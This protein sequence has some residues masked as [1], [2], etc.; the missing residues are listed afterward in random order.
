LVEELAPSRSL[1]RHPL[2]QV[3]LTLQNTAEA[4]LELTNVTAEVLPNVAPVA[5]FDLEVNMVEVFDAHGRPAGLEGLATVAADLFDASTAERVVGWFVRVLEAVTAAPGVR[6]HAVDLLDAGQRE[7]VLVGWNDTVVGGVEATVV[8][9]F[10]RRVVEVPDATAVVA[11]GVEVSYRELD[12]R[13]NRLARYLCGLGV[14]VESVVAV[15]M[16]RGVD[17]VVALLG[18]FKAGAAYLPVDPRYPA[19]RVGFM[20]ADSGAGCVLT[21]VACASLVAEAVPAGVAVTV[22]DEPG[23]ATE[24][25][26]LDGGVL[27]DGQ[28]V[29]ELLPAG[30]A[31]VIYTSGSTGTPKG[32]AVTHAGAANLAVAQ[33]RLLGTGPGARVLQFASIG[34]VGY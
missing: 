1:A 4:A 33:G 7:Q 6:L 3:M 8:E 21:S 20:L 30:L 31:Y 10:E 23:V 16:E 2:F 18:V 28:R 5:R 34:G 11:D 22:L 25:A 12:E 15:V 26:G 9:L 17:V 29:G 14:G 24:L 32:V 19:Q 27:S 13:A